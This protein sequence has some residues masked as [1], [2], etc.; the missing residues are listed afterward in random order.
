MKQKCLNIQNINHGYLK[1]VTDSEKESACVCV[2]VWTEHAHIMTVHRRCSL[3]VMKHD[4]KR[5]VWHR[6]KA[7]LNTKNKEM[8]NKANSYPE[9]KEGKT[10]QKNAR[11]YTL[12]CS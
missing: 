8:R 5:S 12:N 9:R 6:V 7:N 3:S 10:E 2:C 1:S 11:P 4:D